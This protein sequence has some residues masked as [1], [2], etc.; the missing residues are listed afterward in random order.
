MSFLIESMGCDDLFWNVVF[1][2]QLRAIGKRAVIA[3]VE[4]D[5]II[6]QVIV[7]VQLEG[8]T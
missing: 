1:D 7:I 4:R 8:E 2:D 3:A 5:V 6:A